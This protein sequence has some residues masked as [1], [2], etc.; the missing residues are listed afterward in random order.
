MVLAISTTVMAYNI[1]LRPNGNGYDS[2]LNSVGCEPTK[3]MKC[4]NENKLN[5]SNYLYGQWDGLN[6]TF[7]FNNLLDGRG[8]YNISYIE[9]H[10]YAKRYNEN[11]T[12]IDPIIRNSTV[13]YTGSP[14]NLTAEYT[15]VSERFYTNPLTGSKWTQPSVNAIV[16]GFETGNATGLHGGGYVASMYILVNYTLW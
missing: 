13:R 6:E 12:I 5:I 15:D 16:A 11:R 3:H 8:R 10:F 4:V 14:I 9:L 1:L 2:D 7:A